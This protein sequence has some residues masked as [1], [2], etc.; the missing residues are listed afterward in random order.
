MSRS[1]NYELIQTV[2]DIAAQ[3]VKKLSCPQ[4]EQMHA[5]TAVCMHRNDDSKTVQ[6][7]NVGTN[8][9]QEFNLFN[10]HSF[11]SYLEDCCNEIPVPRLVVFA[12]S[13]QWVSYSMWDQIMVTILQ[14][15]IITNES[16]NLFLKFI[17]MSITTFSL[18]LAD[19]CWNHKYV[20]Y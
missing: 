16:F 19:E 20:K 6:C 4:S 12:L 15:N 11:K 9:K 8:L 14:Q 7:T 17:I 10:N 5:Y 3:F 13:N 2:L 1:P 18:I